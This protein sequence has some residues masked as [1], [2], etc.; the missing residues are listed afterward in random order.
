ML[1]EQVQLPGEC[2]HEGNDHA[3][4]ATAFCGTVKTTKQPYVINQSTSQVFDKSD[5]VGGVGFWGSKPG[6]VGG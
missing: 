3:P 1:M 5:Q 4:F 6:G 2:N